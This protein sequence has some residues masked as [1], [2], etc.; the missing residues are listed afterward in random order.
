MLHVDQHR[1]KATANRGKP[2]QTI[3]VSNSKKSDS[4]F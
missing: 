1:I 3:K 4:K 2:I